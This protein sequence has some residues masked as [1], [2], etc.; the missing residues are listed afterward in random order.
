MHFVTAQDILVDMGSKEHSEKFR[1]FMY[2]NV[3][4]VLV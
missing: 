2:V 4:L 3:F 1:T